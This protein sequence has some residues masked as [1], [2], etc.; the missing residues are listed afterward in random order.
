MANFPFIHNYSIFS[1]SCQEQKGPEL[2]TDKN[3]Y[4]DAIFEAIDQANTLIELL[5]ECEADARKNTITLDLVQKI[6]DEAQ[7]NAAKLVCHN[8]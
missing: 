1:R 8:L 3:S 2:M 5:L 7:R 6:L 4:L